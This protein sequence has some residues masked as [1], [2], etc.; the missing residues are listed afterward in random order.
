MNQFLHFLCLGVWNLLQKFCNV[1]N[2]K[3]FMKHHYRV[4]C[5]TVTPN[6]NPTVLKSQESVE[7]VAIDLS[8]TSAPLNVNLTPIKTPHSISPL[9][10]TPSKCTQNSTTLVT[11]ARRLNFPKSPVTR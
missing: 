4:T 9:L 5:M 10:K 1:E 3:L 7:P 11:P 2:L 8:V 6:L